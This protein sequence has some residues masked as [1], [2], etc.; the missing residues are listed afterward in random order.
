MLGSPWWCKLVL[1][2]IWCFLKSATNRK[3]LPV[4]ALAAKG[5][6]P[7]IAANGNFWLSEIFGGKMTFLSKAHQ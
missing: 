3:F 2:G 7:Q 6:F 1:V 5:H 4:K